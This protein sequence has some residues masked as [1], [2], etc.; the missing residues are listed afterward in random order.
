M[1]LATAQSI[2][3]NQALVPM[4][5]HFNTLLGQTMF[6]SKLIPNEAG[7]WRAV[8]C[9]TTL[10]ETIKGYCESGKKQLYNWQ[11]LTKM[12]EN[13][14]K[15]KIITFTKLRICKFCLWYRKCRLIVKDWKKL[16]IPY[17][18]KIKNNSH[19]L[20]VL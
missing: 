1:I 5:M 6:N 20:K 11:L 16:C 7:S 2:T 19:G 13:W 3:E 17:K 4:S 10:L 12:K 18:E 9:K 14:L 8:L 15:T